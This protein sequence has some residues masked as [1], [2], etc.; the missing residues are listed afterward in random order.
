M[1]RY[2]SHVIISR[3]DDIES[4][5]RARELSGEIYGLSTKGAFS[6]DFGLRDQIQVA[7][8]SIMANL[9]E[10]FCR[11]GATEFIRYLTIA[12]SSAIEVQSHLYIALD[13]RYIT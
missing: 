3:F 4:W 9:A 5:R 7:S 12:Q 13:L 6:K 11:N 2:C 1:R 10:G 8:V